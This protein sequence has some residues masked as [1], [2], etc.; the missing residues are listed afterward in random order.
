MPRS[1][2]ASTFYLKSVKYAF[3]LRRIAGFSSFAN[4]SIIDVGAA[5]AFPP[6]AEGDAR[7]KAPEAEGVRKGGAYALLLAPRTHMA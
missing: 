5:L 4:Y 1:I 3:M 7:V 6:A 2:V